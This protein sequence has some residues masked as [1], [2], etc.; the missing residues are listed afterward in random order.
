M[1]TLTQ[2]DHLEEYVEDFLEI[3]HELRWDKSLTPWSGM[4]D[5][6]GQMLLLSEGHSSLLDFIDY[7]LWGCGVVF[8]QWGKWRS[9]PTSPSSQ[10]K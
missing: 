1:F 3:C 6:L 9:R 8:T 4:G 2:D 5:I 7:T 10:Y